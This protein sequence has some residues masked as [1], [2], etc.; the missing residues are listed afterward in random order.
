MSHFD[1]SRNSRINI[2]SRDMEENT[3][4]IINQL[5]VVVS[6]EKGREGN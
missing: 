6:E 5:E 3:E 4:E 2:F 1:S